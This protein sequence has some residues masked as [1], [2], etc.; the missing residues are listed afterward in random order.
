MSS[1]FD[2]VMEL[3]RPDGMASTSEKKEIYRGIPTNTK[4]KM[5][6]YAIE[7]DDE[8]GRLLSFLMD[9]SVVNFKI[10]PPEKEGSSIQ[11]KR[12]PDVDRLD[13]GSR[14]SAVKGRFQLHSSAP[15]KIYGTI[16]SGKKSMTLSLENN[17]P[18]SND[19]Q[20]LS[21]KGPIDDVN[22]L[23]NSVSIADKNAG[24]VLP[25]IDQLAA[26]LTADY[27]TAMGLSALIG[28]GGMGARNLA[29][30]LKNKATGQEDE[31]NPLWQD[32][33]I[34]AGGGAAVS[35]AFKMFGEVNKDM[36]TRAPRFNHH[37]LPWQ[38]MRYSELDKHSSDEDKEEIVSKQANAVSI[39]K[40]QNMLSFDQS[41]S[42][43]DRRVLISQLNQ[44]M[45]SSQGSTIDM[46][47]IRNSGLG[48]LFGYVTA[49]LMG[50]GLPG[51]VGAAAL[52]GFIGNRSTQRGG[53][54][55]DPRGFYSY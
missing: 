21:K 53:K 7:E 31:T 41:L 44:A 27:P 10:S 38:P 55:W 2:S 46:N 49:K 48:M 3:K 8:G 51:Q 42:P 18:S 37:L 39:M 35:G 13:F 30:K 15:G 28:A 11:A 45:Q 33:L 43:A 32:L 26:P 9:D 5:L 24:V 50:F 29:L 36:G 25:T 4:S 34:G 19:W 1:F 12:I 14:G 40:I 17:D 6:D 47:S 52:G 54:Q 22:S 23:I 20:V 16:H